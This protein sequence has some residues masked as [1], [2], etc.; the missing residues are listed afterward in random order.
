MSAKCPYTS[1]LCTSHIKLLS[2]LAK[3]GDLHGYNLMVCRRDGHLVLVPG[4]QTTNDHTFIHSFVRLFSVFLAALP[5]RASFFFSLNLSH[6]RHR[7]IS[8]SLSYWTETFRSGYAQ[9]SRSQDRP[10]PVDA[11]PGTVTPC[12]I[13]PDHRPLRNLLPM[14][15]LLVIP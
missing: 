3:S 2:M 8:E 9:I 7:I 13:S 6:R 1:E 5:R 12:R 4:F 10:I 14:M 15:H 11:C